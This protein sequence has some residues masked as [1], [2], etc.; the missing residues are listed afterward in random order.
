MSSMKHF[1]TR[2]YLYL[3]NE[4]QISMSLPLGIEGKKTL[5]I[6]C[7]LTPKIR[8]FYT[9]TSTSDIMVGLSKLLC[10]D[11]LKSQ[12]HHDFSEVAIYSFFLYKKITLNH[13]DFIKLVVN[14]NTR[15]MS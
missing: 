12:G 13:C 9:S 14:L 5:I 3:P 8:M 10:L 7:S 11:L 4:F 1:L 6:E 2:L 15:L